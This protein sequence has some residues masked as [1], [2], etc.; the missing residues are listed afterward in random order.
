MPPF[1][2]WRAREQRDGRGSHG[3]VCLFQH[4]HFPG[5]CSRRVSRALVEKLIRPLESLFLLRSGVVS[6]DSRFAEPI[7]MPSGI[8]LASLRDAIV[9]LVNTV[10][11]SERG[12]PVILTAAELIT[13]AA[14]RGCPIEFARIATLRALNRNVERVLNPDIVR[15]RIGA[16]AS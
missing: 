15:T 9:Y 13:S 16:A 11:S 5:S 2:A 3:T 10:P 1:Q 4:Q 7:E 8:R 6:W 12:T 14:E